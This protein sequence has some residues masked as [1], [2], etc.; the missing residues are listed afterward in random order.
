MSIVYATLPLRVEVVACCGP[1]GGQIRYA[2]SVSLTTDSH[3]NLD[4]S[5]ATYKT[6]YGAMAAGRRAAYKWA[7]QQCEVVGRW[8]Q[9]K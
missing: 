3:H 6:A 7:S 9:A 2:W 5:C 4:E 1:P 8:K